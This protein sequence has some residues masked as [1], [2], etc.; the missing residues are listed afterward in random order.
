MTWWQIAIILIIVWGIVEDVAE[1]ISRAYIATHR[2]D[3]TQNDHTE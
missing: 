1:S 3:I 2:N